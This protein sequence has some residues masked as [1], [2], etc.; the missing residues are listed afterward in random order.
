MSPTVA[1]PRLRAAL[2]NRSDSAAER[3]ASAQTAPDE[4]DFM[5]ADLF[6]GATATRKKSLE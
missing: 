2:P 3:E 4:R 6:P 1:E 5:T